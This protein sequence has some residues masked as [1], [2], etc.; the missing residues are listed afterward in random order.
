MKDERDGYTSIS[1]KIFPVGHTMLSDVL[2]ENLVFFFRPCSFV[3]M[4]PLTARKSSHVY[5]YQCVFL[6]L[7]VLCKLLTSTGNTE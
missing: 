4:L 7:C 5:D 6:C 1:R 3:N 2:A